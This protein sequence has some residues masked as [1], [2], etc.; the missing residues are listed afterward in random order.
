MAGESRGLAVGLPVV[1]S[2][3]L[4]EIFGEDIEVRTGSIGGKVLF[5]KQSFGTGDVRE[6][7]AHGV[8]VDADGGLFGAD[9]VGQFEAIGFKECFAQQG[10]WD[11][12]ADEF[13]ICGRGKATFAEL[14]D[15]EGKFGLDVGVSVLRVVD[16][17]AVLPLQLWELDRHREIDRSAVAYRIA[18]VV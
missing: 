6:E 14:V 3:C 16:G 18:D 9:D 13:R 5:V 15:V 8:A 7:A 10:K 11:F 4:K 12:E 2:G 17:G 1:V